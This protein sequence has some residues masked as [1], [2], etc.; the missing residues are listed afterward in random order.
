MS[1]SK[2]ITKAIVAGVLVIGI[3]IAASCSK[4]PSTPPK[5][6]ETLFVV[7]IDNFEFTLSQMDQYLAGVSP[8][9]M[10][11]QMIVRMQLAGILGNPELAG[12]NMGGKFR[13]IGVLLPDDSGKAEPTSRMLIAG[14]LPVTDY[15]K[16]IGDNPKFSK[17]DANGISELTVSL[18][19]PG[20]PTAP[21]AAPSGPAMLISKL[22]DGY[23]LISSKG[24]YDKVVRYKKLVAAS[25][26]TGAARYAAVVAESD[27][28]ISIYGDVQT[29]SKAF[30]P[31]VT[32]KFNEFKGMFEQMGAAGQGPGPGM[33]VD[34]NMMG[35]VMNMYAALL[36]TI[37]KEVQSFT[38]AIKPSP[39]VLFFKETVS[40][41]PG[42][43]IAQ[44]LVADTAES[45]ENELLGYLKNG[46]AMNFA[47]K[48]NK[49]F[50]EKASLK[51][52]DLLGTMAG[53]AVAEDDIAK[54]K[55][56]MADS[57]DAIGSSLAGTFAVDTQG[58]SLF[59]MDY[60]VAVKDQAKFNK[61]IDDSFE[62]FET[63]G[64][65]DLYKS[66][67]FEMD[68]TIKRGTETYKG[69]SIDSA[70]LVMKSTEPNSP[71]GQMINAIYG[72]GFDYRWGVVDGL[73]TIAI[74]GDV[75]SSVH[76]L[77]DLVKAGGPEEICSEVQ[78]ALKMLP[79]AGKAD[80]FVT[81]NYI[82][83]LKMASGMM[84]G[85]GLGDTGMTM[86][87][88]NVPSKS[89]IN[90]AGKIGNGNLVVDIAVPKQHLS[91]LVTAFMMLTQQIQAQQSAVRTKATL[92]TLHSAVLQFKMDTG[93]YPADE[94]GLMA[95]VEKPAGITGWEEGGYLTT[96]YMPK[97]AWNKDFVYELEPASGK[98][99]VIISLGADDKEGGEGLN[100]DLFSTD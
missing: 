11:L 70:R 87:E 92:K 17:P 8:I 55:K 89:N 67:G 6:V 78:D 49:P 79:D 22:D 95:L 25:K 47:A 34:P 82:R 85:M 30:G 16:L 57:M 94:E 50:W 53:Q 99:F 18:G 21:N 36:E 59:D 45:K 51:G 35:G 91:E 62:M 56:L 10:G 72:D 33:M 31:L 81:Y 80:I 74:G 83:L 61:M 98:P 19:M 37:M 43:E 93:R 46:V 28:P 42:T 97:D 9:P 32:E 63:T 40:A 52:M 20:M 29:A 4:K 76:K 41:V 90:I 38:L 88:I 2:R 58:E 26:A 73:C 71:P 100:K 68:Y 75:D 3:V 64:I 60:I 54:M 44:M 96:S 15:D 24:Q 14:L 39:D 77:I 23:A 86:P 66:L 65:L 48:M 27:Y 69:V 84:A 7:E 5:S 1:D 13:A 12:L